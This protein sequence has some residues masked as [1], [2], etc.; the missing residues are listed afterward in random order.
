MLDEQTLQ[1]LLFFLL[2]FMFGVSAFNPSAHFTFPGGLRFESVRFFLGF[3]TW[4]A[5]PRKG[6]G[7][8]SLEP[9]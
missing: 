9:F 5:N 1:F 6:T 8:G 3:G 2:S 4:G 7:I